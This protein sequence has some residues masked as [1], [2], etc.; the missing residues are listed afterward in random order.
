[1][2]KKQNN[3]FEMFVELVDY[4]C[5]AAE[6]L[7][8]NLVNF[9]ADKLAESIEIMHHIEQEADHKKHDMI[10]KLIHEFITPIEREDIMSL[11]QEVDDVTDAID[12]VLLKIYMY[13]ITAVR[14]E[15]LEFSGIIVE[16]C[17]QLKIMMEDFHNFKKSTKIK[18]CIIEV[19]RLEEMGD[20]LYTK[21]IRNLYT[22]CQ[23]PI[24]IIAW[25]EAFS[26]L[27]KCCDNCEDIADIVESVVMK[28]T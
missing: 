8:E 27:E 20:T 10:N 6:T 5:K 7:H 22:T 13:N 4:C 23:D 2:A 26:R 25:T 14:P 28:N 9:D 1:M 12:D 3:Y 19:N 15:T 18:E 21:A 17:K 24:E 16:S 11:A